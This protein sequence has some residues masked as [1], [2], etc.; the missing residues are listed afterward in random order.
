MYI[1]SFKLRCSKSWIQEELP[2]L[3]PGSYQFPK[4]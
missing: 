1:S 2:K 3:I 4:I